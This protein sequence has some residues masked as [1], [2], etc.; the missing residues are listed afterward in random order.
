MIFGAKIRIIDFLARNAL[1]WVI[2][3]AKIKKSTASEANCDESPKNGL[4]RNFKTILWFSLSK[5]DDFRF[6]TQKIADLVPK[7]VVQ[8][9]AHGFFLLKSSFLRHFSATKT[10]KT[11]YFL[12]FSASWGLFSPKIPHFWVVLGGK[13]KPHADGFL[14]PKCSFLRHENRKNLMSFSSFESILG[15]F[16]TENPHFRV[17]FEPK[18][19][20]KMHIRSQKSKLSVFSL[21]NTHFW[22]ILGAKTTFFF[23]RETNCDR[24]PVIPKKND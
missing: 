13:N 10:M 18:S 16:S 2:L 5:N 21:K 4:K 3:D 6:K 14:K 9:R 22:V 15:S 17:I 19:L 24:C 11:W 23:F 20:R 7:T 1:F 12:V 8:N